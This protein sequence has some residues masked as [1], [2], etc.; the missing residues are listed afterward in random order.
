MV[1]EKNRLRVLENS[2]LDAIHGAS[3]QVLEKTGVQVDSEEALGILEK[4]GYD[5]DRKT[6]R[7]RMTESK[8]M[9]AVKSCQKNWR[10]HARSEKHSIDMV[11]GRTKFGPGS[12]CLLYMDPWTD[13]IREATL[14][15]GILICRLLDALDSC[16]LGYLPTYPHDVPPEAMSI[17]WWMA[18]L[19]NTSKPVCGGGGDPAEFELT[20]RLTEIFWGSREALSKKNVFPAYIDPISPLSHDKYMTETLLRHALHDSP[21]FVMVMALAGGTAPASLAGLLVQQNAE[22]LSAI[23][24]AKCVQKMPKIVYGSVSCPLDMRSGI[25][26][27]GAPEFSLIGIGTVQ[28]A[29][30]YGLPSD[31]GVQSDSKTVDAQTTYEKTQSA[32][33][34]TLAG[35]DFSDLGMGSTEAFTLFSPIQLVID[36][37]I[38][39]NVTRIAEGIAVNDKTLSVDVIAKTGPGGNFLKQKEILKQFRQEHSQPAL[40]DRSPRQHWA[41]A[42]ATKAYDR[43]RTRVNHILGTHQPEPLEPNVRQG[44]DDLILQYT[45][46]YNLQRLETVT[47]P[48]Q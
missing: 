45:K 15:D 4:N 7:V 47:T 22:I 30:Y 11:D 9:E 14:N 1:S 44:I 28:M 23:A 19:A 25:S 3:M 41:G 17:V 16:S 48:F 31:A 38:V 46:E 39:S 8:V 6:K 10:W 27:T 5:V 12:Q 26:A 29:K 18:G 34:I 42:G 37:E 35:A 33:S 24:I 2:D 32:L 13:E 36:D 20:Q 21:V 40:S 43:A